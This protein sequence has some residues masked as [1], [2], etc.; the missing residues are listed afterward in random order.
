MLLFFW[1]GY[2]FVVVFVIILLFVH[3]WCRGDAGAVSGV[4][5]VGRICVCLCVVIILLFCTYSVQG[6][7]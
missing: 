6:W 2:V 3:I 4:V 5:F 1:P 7:C